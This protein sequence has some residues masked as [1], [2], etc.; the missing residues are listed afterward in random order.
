MT[1]REQ[2]HELKAKYTHA[3]TDTGQESEELP[4]TNFPMQSRAARATAAQLS[5]GVNDREAILQS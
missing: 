3:S 4:A 5:E 1:T 2:L